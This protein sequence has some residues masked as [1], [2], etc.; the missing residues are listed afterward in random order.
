MEI[1]LYKSHKHFAFSVMMIK[2][3]SVIH[4]CSFAFLCQGSNHYLS[5]GVKIT[6]NKVRN[7]YPQLQTLK[8]ATH[9]KLK[10]CLDDLG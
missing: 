6:A 8:Y 10:L 5:H 7:Q 4:C 3:S 9:N 2:M 1:K